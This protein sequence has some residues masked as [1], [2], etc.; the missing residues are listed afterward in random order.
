MTFGRS[1]KSR[2]ATNEKVSFVHEPELTY[3]NL[4][5]VKDSIITPHFGR[6]RSLKSHDEILVRMCGRRT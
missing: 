4:F 3:F 5:R 2:A 6:G 1:Q